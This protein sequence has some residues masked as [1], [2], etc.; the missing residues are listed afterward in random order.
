MLTMIMV[1]GCLLACAAP[2][3]KLTVADVFKALALDQAKLEY[4]DEPPGKLREVQCEAS[5]RDTNVK[6]RVRI[7]IVYAPELFSM[8]RKWDPKTVRAAAVRKVTISPLGTD[9]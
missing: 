2:A 8:E 7:E 4:I 5:L 1:S 3:E 6:A 9:R